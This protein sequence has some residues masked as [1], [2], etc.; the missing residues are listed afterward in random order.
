MTLVNILLFLVLNISPCKCSIL[1]SELNADAAGTS[2]ADFI[3]LVNTESIKKSLDGY[4]LVFYNGALNPLEA[5]NVVDMSGKCISGYG[6]FVVGSTRVSPASDI[7]V[8][9]IQNG[10]SNSADAVALYFTEL[11]SK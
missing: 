6:S 4:Y 1:I 2:E 9:S 10:N 7:I 5:Y 3:E 11:A 8:T